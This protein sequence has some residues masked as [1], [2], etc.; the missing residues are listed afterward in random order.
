MHLD[1]VTYVN[2]VPTIDGYE[3]I[4]TLQLIGTGSIETEHNMSV[5]LPTPMYEIALEND[6]LYEFDGKTFFINTNSDFHQ[7]IYKFLLMFPSS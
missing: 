1:K 3:P 7:Y 6:S 2:E 4:H 5:P